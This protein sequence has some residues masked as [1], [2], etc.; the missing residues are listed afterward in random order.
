MQS[1][2]QPQ[3]LLLEEGIQDEAIAFHKEL[4]W[5]HYWAAQG[6]PLRNREAQRWF[7]ERYDDTFG[8]SG[9]ASSLPE[10][11]QQRPKASQII[12]ALRPETYGRI[13]A[14]CPTLDQNDI[15][16]LEATWRTWLATPGK[17]PPRQPDAAFIAFCQR[18]LEG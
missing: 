13:Q 7:R 8:R 12:P 14:L 11:R 3:I 18:K 6:K 4:Y 9:K 2:K 5:I 10:P 1:G 15:A 16:E 17:T